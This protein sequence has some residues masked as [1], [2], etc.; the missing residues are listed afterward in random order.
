MEKYFNKEWVYNWVK[1][2]IRGYLSGRKAGSK[3]E[4]TI[5]IIKRGLNYLNIKISKQQ[6]HEILNDYEFNK[7]KSS[8]RYKELIERCEEEALL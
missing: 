4:P 8:Q 7:Y 2:T 6:L 5:G 3:L 1:G